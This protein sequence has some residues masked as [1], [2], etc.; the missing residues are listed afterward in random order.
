M[1]NNVDIK[2]K[3]YF[4]Q[5]ETL[6]QDYLK[7]IEK[8]VSET[9]QQTIEYSMTNGGKRI[10]P[11]LGLATAEL[12]GVDFDEIKYFLLA[13]EFIQSYSLVHDDLPAMDNDDYRRGKLS[14]HKKFGEAF[15]I[16]A[17]DALL[18]LAFETCLKKTTFNENDIDAM[19]LIF[20]FSGYKGMVAGQTLDLEQEKS[21]I[22][23]ETM[24][25]N[26][27]EN[28]TVKM[29]KAPLLVA[30]ILAGKKYFNELS[31][32]G[33]NLGMCFQIVDDII[34]VEGSFE[35][36]GKTPNKDLLEDKL[37][38]VKIFGLDGAKRLAES[39]YNNALISIINIEGNNFLVEFAKKIYL[40]KS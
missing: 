8:S 22:Y 31:S 13:L 16:L 26:I 11:V 15:G 12:L 28:K 29:F 35:L 38:S 20:D 10:R 30:S 17:G 34:D 2:Y 36:I 7:N 37:T 5:F 19:R 27:Y 32:F 14:T 1:Q 40:R 33:N 9:I 39:Y 25:N 24:L 4:Y 3:E 21:K 23:N 18:N 6:L